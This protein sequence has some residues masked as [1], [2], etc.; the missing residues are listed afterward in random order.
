ML[1]GVFKKPTLQE[2]ELQCAKIGLPVTEAGKF[3]D[4][5][6][7]CGWFVGRKRMVSWVSAL[8]GWKRRW[9]EWGPRSTNRGLS[10]ADKVILQKELER[11]M[12]Q[13]RIIRSTYGD[14]QTWTEQD[15]AAYK[16]YRERRD[17]I[18][19]QL[20]ILI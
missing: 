4:Y 15:K 2:V 9:E 13:I 1:L 11:C 5:Y 10:G 16:R 19:I 7:S 18:R 14:H 17:Q 12:E 8:S 6:E 3:I 20:G